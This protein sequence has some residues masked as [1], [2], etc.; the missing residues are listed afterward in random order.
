VKKRKIS[1]SKGQVNDLAFAFVRLGLLQMRADDKLE[2]IGIC[3][4]VLTNGNP[5]VTLLSCTSEGVG[6]QKKQ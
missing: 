1:E 3:Q 4:Y 6:K 5:H 2:I